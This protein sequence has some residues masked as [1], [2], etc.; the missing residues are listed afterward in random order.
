[1]ALDQYANIAEIVGV[2]IVIVT[3]V[4]L[5]LQ[6]RQNT[7]AIRS[8]TIQAVSQSEMSIAKILIE[9]SDT[10]NKVLTAE[11][12]AVGEET[13]KAIGLFN[14]FM[15]DTGHRYQQYNT[16]Y[17]DAQAWEGR[18]ATLPEVTNL[19]V[20]QLWKTSLGGMSHS[21]DFLELLENQSRGH[22]GEHENQQN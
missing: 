12:L 19:P 20:Y 6:I 21:A 15:I 8:T 14:V 22:R 16:G 10:W 4:F 5:T 9:N 2:V 1:M 11:P 3:L 17:L 13:R 7:R 18:L